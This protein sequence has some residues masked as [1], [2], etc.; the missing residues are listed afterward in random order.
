MSLLQIAA[1]HDVGGATAS[2]ST[3][4]MKLEARKKPLV[5]LVMGMAGSGKTTLLQR[6]NLYT[7]E[8]G[9]N[10]Y[11]I[12]LDPA[13]K[14]VPRGRRSS[15][16]SFLEI[17]LL[18]QEGSYSE[19]MRFVGASMGLYVFVRVLSVSQARVLLV[20]TRVPLLQVLW[21]Y[22]YYYCTYFI[23]DRDPRVPYVAIPCCPAVKFCRS[24]LHRTR[25]TFCVHSSWPP[26]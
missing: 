25:I 4:K 13:V 6:L 9:I 12:N 7:A 2:E 1:K 14:Q 15:M 11:F 3:K 8:K 20:L 16:T 19:S 23:S 21:N 18:R 22:Y 17:C 5:C 24:Y 26:L 10:S